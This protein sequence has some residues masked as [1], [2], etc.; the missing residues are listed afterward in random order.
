MLKLVGISRNNYGGYNRWCVRRNASKQCSRL[1]PTHSSQ[2]KWKEYTLCITRHTTAQEHEAECPNSP[3]A[4][5][6]L[7][8]GESDR[9]GERIATVIVNT[10][11]HE[12]SLL[13]RQEFVLVGE[14]WYKEP[15]HDS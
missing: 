4:E 6:G 9:I 12:R 15:I 7:Y 8:L 14:R 2:D 1:G 5:V 3:V 13:W 10:L 11:E